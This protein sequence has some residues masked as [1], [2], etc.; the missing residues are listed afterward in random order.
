[1]NFT[2]VNDA[3]LDRIYM[4]GPGRNEIEV[5]WGIHLPDLRANEYRTMLLSAVL[6]RKEIKLFG[7][8]FV[9]VG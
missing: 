2:S 9:S 4:N 6:G 5:T 7:R 3:V 1:M 8:Y